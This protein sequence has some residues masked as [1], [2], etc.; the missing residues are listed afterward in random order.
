MKLAEEHLQRLVVAQRELLGEKERRR[1]WTRA[2]YAMTVISVGAAAGLALAAA[3]PVIGVAV[4]VIGFG[5]WVAG[6]IAGPNLL[7][8]GLWE[9]PL[10]S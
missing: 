5:G 10:F 1:W 8:R 9:G 4:P 7:N 6:K 2:E 3:L